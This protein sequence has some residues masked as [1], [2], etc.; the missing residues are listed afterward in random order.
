MRNNPVYPEY[1]H[2]W[3]KPGRHP[4][5]AERWFDLF[6]VR[7]SLFVFCF[8]LEKHIE[9][10]YI[11]RGNGVLG[12]LSTSGDIRASRGFGSR[13]EQK[14]K[15]EEINNGEILRNGTLWGFWLDRVH[16]PGPQDKFDVIA[17][18]GF[19]RLRGRLEQ[20]PWAVAHVVT[21]RA[22]PFRVARARVVLVLPTAWRR[23]VDKTISLIRQ[24][25][26]IFI[27]FYSKFLAICQKIFTALIK[28]PKGLWRDG[29]SLKTLFVRK[30][31]AVKSN[32]S[33]YYRIDGVRGTLHSPW[34][35]N[36]FIIFDNYDR[37]L[38]KFLVISTW[39]FSTKIF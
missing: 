32:K 3:G 15:K 1:R 4:V 27:G 38:G 16:L 39:A 24:K 29:F 23:G 10:K 2:F 34:K 18:L 6:D 20:T 37:F 26:F 28:N 31:A 19:H 25:Q 35:N 13:T 14:K 36:L 11:F 33:L 22:G 7:F 30:I 9:T 17:L 8:S 5:C 21:V 12:N